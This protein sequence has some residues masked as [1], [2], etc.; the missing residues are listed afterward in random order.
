MSAL[1]AV[2]LIFAAAVVTLASYIS[3]VYSEFGKIFRAKCRTTSMPGRNRS[4][5]T[6]G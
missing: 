2:L 6:S 4:S 3:R 5:R 1:T